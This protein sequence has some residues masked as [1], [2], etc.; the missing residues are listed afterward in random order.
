MI[1]TRTLVLLLVLCPRLAAA[2]TTPAGVQAIVRGDYATAVDLLTPMVDGED[3]DPVAAFFLASLHHTGRG[4]RSD[5]EQACSLYSDAARSAASPLARQGQ[6]LLG[7]IAGSGATPLFWDLCE[8][9]R[10]ERRSHRAAAPRLP[11]NRAGLTPA[12]AGAAAFAS[13]DFVRA[14]QIL[15]PLAEGATPGDGAAAFLVGVM[16]ENGLGLS[17]DDVKACAMYLRASQTSPLG[18]WPQDVLVQTV[19][20]RLTSAQFQ[21]ASTLSIV[22]LDSGFEPMV[23]TLGSAQWVTIDLSGIAVADQGDE[24]RHEAAWKVPGSIFLPAR[25]TQLMTGPQ[26]DVPRHFVEVAQWIPDGPSPAEW[27]LLWR[28][29]EVRGLD[30]VDVSSKPLA[31]RARR[32]DLT[33]RGTLD[34]FVRLQVSDIGDAE[35]V[36][37]KPVT[38]ASPSAMFRRRRAAAGAR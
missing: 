34:D 2:Q 8:R 29:Y 17:P 5:Y 33:T 1:S 28:L 6:A 7:D 31:V 3:P 37:T 4:V 24:R 9:A 30:V 27:Q 18:D 19:A 20:S 22:G 26:R 11:A 35:W 36:R 32:P 16:Y 12:E 14:A 21:M 13:G 15:R 23:A 38:Q 10:G 25:Y